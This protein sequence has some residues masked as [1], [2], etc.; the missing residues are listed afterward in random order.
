[1]I[2][3]AHPPVIPKEELNEGTVELFTL[4][5]CDRLNDLKLLSAA[6]AVGLDGA[7]RIDCPE[8][9][10]GLTALAWKLSRELEEISDEVQA[11]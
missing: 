10:D 3:H 2:G 11:T 1:V 5:I 9:I 7:R 8:A 6:I 4:A